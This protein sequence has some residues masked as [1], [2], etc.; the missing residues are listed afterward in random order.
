MILPLATAVALAV[1]PVQQE[2]PVRRILDLA[3][4]GRDSLLVATIRA[5]PVAA[6]Q[7]F[8]DALQ[9]GR[10]EIPA[11]VAD[12]A[13]AFQVAWDDP[14]LMRRLRRFTD[15]SP[16]ERRRKLLTDSLRAEGNLAWGTLGVA[17][18]R[19]YWTAS[20]RISEELHD[21]AGIAAALGNLGAAYYVSG[22][23]DSAQVSYERSRAMAW[24]VGEVSTAGNAL[25]MLATLARDAGDLTVAV[26]HYTDALTAHERTGAWGSA[27]SDRHNIG[28]LALRMGDLDVARTELQRALDLSRRHATSADVAEHLVALGEVSTLLGRYADAE[29]ALRE[30]SG[31]AAAAGSALPAAA[32]A[33]AWGLLDLVR[34]RYAA[35]R[36]RFE[37]AIRLYAGLGRVA[38]EVQARTDLSRI[39]AAVGDVAGAL[40][41]LRGA[42]TLAEEHELG[43]SVRASHAMVAGELHLLLNETANARDALIEAERLYG[44]MGDAYGV[45]A[46]LRAQAYVH[47]HQDD[48]ALARAVLERSMNRTRPLDG[49]PRP[50]ALTR[51]LLAETLKRAGDRVAARTSLRNALDVFTAMDD[52]VG[53][54]TTLAMLGDL[55]LELQGLDEAEDAFD[56]ALTVLD[57]VV[58]PEV[59]WRLHVGL[60]RVFEA[61]RQPNAAAAEWSRAV[62]IIEAYAVGSP[63]SFLASASMQDKWVAYHGLARV[64]ARQGDVADAFGTSERLRAQRLLALMDRGAVEGP[65]GY[66]DPELHALRGR[67]SRLN[68][69]RLDLGGGADP[70]RGG[71]R[72]ASAETLDA[73]IERARSEYQARL[74]MLQESAPR[75]SVAAPPSIPDI[76]ARLE[77]GETLV[78]YLLGDSSAFVF[79]I[80]E[81]T[82]AVVELEE[83]AGAIADLVRFVRASLDGSAVDA[84]SIWHSPLRRLHEILVQP[85][86]DGGWLSQARALIVV[87]H[88]P[89]HY[90]PFSAL[91]TREGGFLGEEL[92]LATTPSAAIWL[93]LRRDARRGASH[94]VLAMAPAMNRLPGTRRELELLGAAEK[95]DVV[96]LLGSAA[97]EEAFKADASRFDVVHLASIGELVPANPLFSF[98]EFAPGGGED[99]R[100][101]VHELMT[102]SINA[103]LVVLSACDTGV[104]AG[105]LSD[106]P[107]GD[108]WVGFVQGF[109]AAGAQNVLA[110]LWKVDDEVTADLMAAFY[111]AWRPGVTARQALATAQRTIAAG[112]GTAHPYYWS[113]FVLV[114]EGMAVR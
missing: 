92:L 87:P 4:S 48:V 60:G 9:S 34:G 97:T 56:R 106:V 17:E 2:A 74:S 33:Q 14:V 51:L 6:R 1:T 54:A 42:R 13:R 59:R 112:E 78:Q 58:A 95:D 5:D 81:H 39:D 18:A 83:S 27:A 36:S 44:S 82:S 25:N 85:L 30:A 105:S 70:V 38:D 16:E 68:M 52:A 40:E 12:I 89:L 96:S 72:L 101:E 29:E 67:I 3:G 93:D 62:S 37:E 94:G 99:G 21:S 84:A 66:G 11:L 107:P 28:L 20:L 47:L 86:A 50:A 109:L 110:T 75:D 80:T 41:T 43:A 114:G 103:R 111:E 31:L 46:A 90:V 91:V 7:A 19:S 98:V 77:D 71:G 76:Q 113:G 15:W 24:A 8:Q 10:G 102:L 69:L 45:A 61:R 79:V 64:R 23:A 32:A 35:A 73:G 108:D 100:L 55:S 88:G 63:G 57:G 104:G 49:S 53:V 65:A 22:Q 26:T